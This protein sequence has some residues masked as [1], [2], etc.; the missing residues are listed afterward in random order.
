MRGWLL[1]V[2]GVERL[3][4]RG[5]PVHA[6]DTLTPGLAQRATPEGKVL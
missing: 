6:A 2:G 1:V 4:R 3:Q 5:L